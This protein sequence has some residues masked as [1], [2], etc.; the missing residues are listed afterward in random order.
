[1]YRFLMYQ[2]AITII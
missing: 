1:M 2:Q